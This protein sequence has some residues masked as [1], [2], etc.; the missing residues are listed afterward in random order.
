[1]SQ[2]VGFDAIISTGHQ[3]S[4]VPQYETDPPATMAVETENA[5]AMPGGGSRR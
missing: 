3:P 4:R 2:F 5:N 1:M